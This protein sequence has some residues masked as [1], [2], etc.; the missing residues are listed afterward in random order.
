MSLPI[1]YD[2]KCNKKGE[3]EGTTR[4]HY[5][6]EELHKELARQQTHITQLEFELAE[7]VKI[8]GSTVKVEVSGPERIVYNEKI[9]DKI[10]EVPGPERIVEVLVSRP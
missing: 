3:T 8:V 9:V 4:M 7:A 10:V 1:R 5:P 6:S 2:D